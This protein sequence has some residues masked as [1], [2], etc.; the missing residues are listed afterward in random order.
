MLAKSNYHS[1]SILYEKGVISRV[2]FEK[3]KGKF[4]EAKSTAL[5][6][7]SEYYKNRFALKNATNNGYKSKA[8]SA[9][10]LIAVSKQ[11]N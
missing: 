6:V 10:A 11:A 7:K 3:Q 2:E 5:S 1:D 4:L 9:Q 8:T